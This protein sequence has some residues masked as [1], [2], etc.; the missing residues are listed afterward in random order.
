[1][2]NLSNQT[3]RLGLVGISHPARVAWLL[4][5]LIHAWPLVAVTLKI[6][7]T[8]TA[9]GIASGGLLL[10]VTAFFWA[11]ALDAVWLR[12][13]RP[14]AELGVWLLVGALMHPVGGDDVPQALLVPPAAVLV[15]AV[16]MQ[17]AK[18]RF[19]LKNRRF[20]RFRR[21]ADCFYRLFATLKT[22]ARLG[23]CAHQRA[24]LAWRRD[25]VADERVPLIRAGAIVLPPP[26]S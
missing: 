18:S 8:P 17:S 12:A 11:K 24:L 16:A 2:Q 5:A 15:A 14:W 10:A 19:N 25:L 21:F 22:E 23:L 7:S 26:V 1:M 13:D 20:Y 3:R 6:L 4:L 9:S